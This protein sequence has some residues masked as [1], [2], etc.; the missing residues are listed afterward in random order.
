MGRLR[1]LT[2]GAEIYYSGP[3]AENETIWMPGPLNSPVEVKVR[4]Q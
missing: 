2:Y 4:D 1:Y 3:N